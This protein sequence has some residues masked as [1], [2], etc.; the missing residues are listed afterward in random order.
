MMTS[1]TV[2]VRWNGFTTKWYLEKGYSKI[3]QGDYFE[4]RVEDLPPGSTAKVLVDC[5][6]KKD[7]CKG[8]HEK[9]YRQYTEDEE[10][11]L[12]NCCTNKKCGA[13]KTKDIMM[14]TY[15][16]DNIQKLDE[17]KIASRE[18]QQK[19]FQ[20]MINQAINK[21][22]ILITK[23]YEYENKK[24]R[25]KF[26]CLAHLEYDIQE[27]NA[28]TFLNNKGCCFY[29]KYELSAESTRNDGNEVYKAF[30]DKGL[31]PKFEPEE[32]RKNIQMLPFICPEHLDKGVQ[33]RS[34]VKLLDSD[35]KCNYCAYEFTASQLRHEKSFIFDYFKNRGL[36]VCE[37]QLYGGVHTHIEFECPNHL[38]TIQKVTY[39]SLMN[40]KQ[41]CELCRAEES[42][43]NLNRRLRSSINSW[44]K[45]SKLNGNNECIFTGN[46]Q[47]DIHHLKAF[48]EIITEA[49]D[50]LSYEIK[51]K[52]NGDEFIKI[53]DKVI[54]LHNKYPIGICISNNIHI[55]FH[56]LY[57]KNASI[58]DF[59]E[60]KLRYELGEFK[61]ILEEVS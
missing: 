43:K 51:Q 34:Y 60:F 14:N 57:S 31:I 3:K 56:Q 55:L 29:G 33:H 30:V 53:R 45:Q 40:T 1:K 38:G 25:I 28:E 35:H 47:Y 2:M 8:I 4:C 19:P 15:G 48:N 50:I 39:H 7:G 23:R 12:G 36:K 24:S 61:S 13:Y 49:L 22:L 26:I 37:N 20:L 10:N 42:L 21:N 6:Y 54:E 46:K 27:T 59:Y 44:R 9:P 16:V 32:Y 52:Y 41:P 17:Y 58:E 11:G 18:R 5:D